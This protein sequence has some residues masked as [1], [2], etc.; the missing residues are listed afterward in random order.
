MVEVVKIMFWVAYSL[1]LYFAVFWFMVL[2]ENK[3][4]KKTKKLKKFPF[5]SIV[6]PAYNEEKKITA[7]IKSVM[8]LD[9]PK[10]KYEVL[11]VDDGSADNTGN[12][13][14]DII[15]NNKNFD[16]RLIKQVNK[17]KG[18]ALNNALKRCKGEFF[19]C[20]DADSYVS[21][22][23][24]HKLLP[25][26]ED[27]EVAVALPLL[28]VRNPESLLQK[29]QWLEYLV[30][31]FY[32]KLMSTLDCV[33]VSP[34]PFSAYR[35]SMLKEVGGF[36]E[37][38]LTEDLEISLRLQN[39]NYKIVQLL[40]TE[41]FTI[42]PSTPKELWRQRNRWYK[43]STLNALH[44]RRM[45]FNKKYGD[46]G[47]IQMPT[48]L[49]SG[50]IAIML[51][52][53]IL[54]YALKPIVNYIYHLSFV[55]FDIITII[56]NFAVNFHYLDMNFMTL[57]LILIMLGIT[58]FIVKKSHKQTH[59]KNIMKYGVFSFLSY[60]FLY[61]FV[62]GTIWIGVVFDLLRGKRQRW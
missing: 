47:M 1:S 14:K 16:I 28:K 23:A 51:M 53:S 25:E 43:G 45:I 33:H 54:Y 18:A 31:M 30:N 38:N 60:L 9:Y 32:K 6:I 42:A 13:T 59:E 11:V 62:L 39:H 56:K 3:P 34:G 12:V 17:G 21:K 24:L 22:D 41:I 20:L 15:K 44:Y 37:D 50:A 4:R 19:I 52:W 36:D 48:V 58:L 46:F 8:K 29:M 61:F 7:T 55:N 27:L 2:L 49:L 5:V 35:K 10:N 26:F 57:L 40:N